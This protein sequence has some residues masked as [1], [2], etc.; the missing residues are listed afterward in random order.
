MVF[1]GGLCRCPGQVKAGGF[2]EIRSSRALLY[3]GSSLL[4]GESAVR[5]ECVLA[6]CMR[7]HAADTSRPV[8]PSFALQPCHTKRQLPRVTRRNRSR[9]FSTNQSKLGN[10][11]SGSRTWW[12]ENFPSHIVSEVKPDVRSYAPPHMATCFVHENA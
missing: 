7:P 11:R 4:S 5:T 10:E 1:L 12:Q 6:D 2:I 3:I 8:G 9:Y